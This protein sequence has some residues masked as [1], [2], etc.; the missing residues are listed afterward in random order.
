[1]QLTVGQRVKRGEDDFGT[2]ESIQ[3]RRSYK[4]DDFRTYVTVFWDFNGQID[5]LLS[6]FKRYGGEIEELPVKSFNLTIR[7]TVIPLNE[8]ELKKLIRD[9]QAILENV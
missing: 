8:I 5:H 6:E 1:M 4:S 7:N 3:E 2:I 9:A